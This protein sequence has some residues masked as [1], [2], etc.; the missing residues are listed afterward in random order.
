ML[1]RR[2]QKR[3]ILLGSTGS[4]GRQTLD[5]VRAF[6]QDFRIV[7]LSGHS[8]PDEL[9]R[10]IEEFEPIAAAL[11]N[12][13]VEPP[14]GPIVRWYR[15]GNGAERMIR[16]IGADIVLNGIA[17][18]AGLLPSFAALESGKDLALANKETMVMAG[19]IALDLARRRRRRILPVD[20][21]HSAVYNLLARF[22]GEPAEIILTASGGAFR[23][24]PLSDL[25]RVT[26]EDA[27]RHP[28]WSMGK[29]ITVD[30]ATMANKALE[31][32]E[33]CR[34]FGLPPR[35]VKVVIHPQ[36]CVHALVR[37]ADGALYAHMSRP[38]MRL[39][40]LAALTAPRVAESD[41][42]RLD[43]ENCRLDFS[44]VDPARYPLL[45]LGYRAAEE[46]GALPVV[47][48][49][50]NEI[51]AAAFIEGEISFLDIER[52]VDGTMTLGWPNLNRSLDD[53]IFNDNLARRKAR[54]VMSDIRNAR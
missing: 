49:A 36:S 19:E 15:G 17:G 54:A 29:K 53:V 4:I 42:G 38:D 13:T 43:L 45:E 14:P 35:R 34:F 24:R 41:F 8:R 16:E 11:T 21:E 7:A 12:G 33:A 25:G 32:M 44:P 48:N 9:A 39:P 52:V 31:V 1:H 46:G 50:A 22:P 3:I 23:D 20:S 26:V 6:P 10:Q 18:A 28:T 40:I 30:S 27:L 2:R 37:A 5:I 51:A 47:F